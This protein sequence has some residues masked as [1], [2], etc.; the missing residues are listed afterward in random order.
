MAF[1]KEELTSLDALSLCLRTVVPT[2]DGM[3]YD[4]RAAFTHNSSNSL[5]L[6]SHFRLCV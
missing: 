2:K 3:S 1:G 4:A 6:A 5:M